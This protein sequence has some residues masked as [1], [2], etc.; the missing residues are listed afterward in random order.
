MVSIG[1]IGLACQRHE[2]M[3]DFTHDCLSSLDQSPIV[4]IV[5]EGVWVAYM[6]KKMNIS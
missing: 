2:E 3:N 4:P 5:R 1:T 6:N